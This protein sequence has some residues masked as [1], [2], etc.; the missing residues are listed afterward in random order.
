M[1]NYK[2]GYQ[3]VKFKNPVTSSSDGYIISDVDREKLKE[4]LKSEKP[5][6]IDF[7]IFSVVDNILQHYKCIFNVECNDEEYNLV[8]I[9][10]SDAG[11]YCIFAINYVISR[12]QFTFNVQSF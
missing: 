8:S 10:I 9:S 1:A 3:I 11:D 12:E 2:G 7:D 5:L 4:S 6:L